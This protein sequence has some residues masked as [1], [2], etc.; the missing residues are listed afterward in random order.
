MINIS[1]ARVFENL[2]ISSEQMDDDIVNGLI[3]AYHNGYSEKAEFMIFEKFPSGDVTTHKK[4]EKA[5]VI[6]DAKVIRYLENTVRD[7][8]I[9]R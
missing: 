6:V 9:F 4:G 8:S 5:S 3:E 7:R 1:D 2:V